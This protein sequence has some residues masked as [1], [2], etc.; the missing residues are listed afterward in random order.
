MALGPD[1]EKNSRVFE[2]DCAK[3]VEGKKKSTRSKTPIGL[4]TRDW[5]G[6]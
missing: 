4:L 5:L 2:M 1:G 6:N 3:R